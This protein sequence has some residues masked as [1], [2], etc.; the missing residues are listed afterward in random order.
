MEAHMKHILLI[1]NPSAGMGVARERLFDIICALAARDCEVTVY[2]LLVKDG[3]TSEHILEEAGDRFDIVSCFG[4]DG[5]LSH[6]V[7]GYIAFGLT[8]PMGYLPAGST[9]D[10]AR[11]LGVPSDCV[12][13]AHV[14]ATGRVFRY[15]VGQFNDLY[16]NYVAAFGAF[17]K[18]TYQ[19]NQTFKNVLGYAAYVVSALLN[20]AE[21]VN[22][23][24]PML[25]EHDGIKE[26]CSLIFGAISNSTSIGGFKVPFD[27]E[28]R[29]DDGLFE[30]ILIRAPENFGEFT[31]IVGCLAVGSLDNPF[32]ETFQTSSLRIT[33]RSKAAW[34]LDGEYG[35]T[36]ET[37]QITCLK[38]RIPLIVSSNVAQA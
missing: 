26:E 4:G 33:S 29:M 18:V 14:I 28:V 2:P 17:T 16:F 19:T 15:D 27:K 8:Q 35:G 10:F 7:N 11:S 25:I 3:L 12:E 37:V 1:V 32:I 21:S 34:T 23:R 13:G 9:N 38:E 6:M 24:C 36:P 30:V 20:V 5:T 31:Q 22:V